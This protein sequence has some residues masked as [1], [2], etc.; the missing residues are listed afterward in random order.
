MAPVRVLIMCDDPLT[1]G[2]LGAL[3]GDRPEV[4]VVGQSE[5][6]EEADESIDLFRP[7]LVLLAAVRWTDAVPALARSLQRL[8][9]PVVAIAEGERQAAAFSS[10][11]ARGV[12]SRDASASDIAQAIISVS[13]G[14]VVLSPSLA[15]MLL[16]SP[17]PVTRA[18]ET[19]LTDR[20]HEVLELIAQGLPNKTIASR[21]RISEHTVKFHVNSILTKLGAE[22][23]TEAV[24]LATRAGLVH[25]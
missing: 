21:L 9:V 23:R 22:S 20:E 19:P 6:V 13:G 2:G 12:L 24:V 5:L 7:D 11:G 4:Q 15:E 16:R 1:R 8:D 18:D 17:T 3:L 10:S 25:L 14:L